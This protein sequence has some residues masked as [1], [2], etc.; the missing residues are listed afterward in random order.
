MLL[1]PKWLCSVLT[2]PGDFPTSLERARM[3]QDLGAQLERRGLRF[4]RGLLFPSDS[5]TA[6]AGRHAS[7]RT[8]E[9]GS[10]DLLTRTYVRNPVRRHLSSQLGTW[11]SHVTSLSLSFHIGKMT[12]MRPSSQCSRDSGHLLCVPRTPSPNGSWHGKREGLGSGL[13]RSSREPALE[14]WQHQTHTG[15]PCANWKLIGRDKNQPEK[16]GR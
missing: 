13:G 4:V 16:L 3:S 1:K 2:W 7:P 14:N 11:A 12:T 5:G 8:G 10:R 6:V 9:H 15:L